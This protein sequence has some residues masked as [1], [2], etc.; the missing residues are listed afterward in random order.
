M[1]SIWNKKSKIKFSNVKTNRIKNEGDYIIELT[2]GKKVDLK[3][4]NYERM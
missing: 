3:I 4:S 1:R 2:D